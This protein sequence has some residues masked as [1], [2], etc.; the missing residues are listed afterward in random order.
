MADEKVRKGHYETS[1]RELD[2]T[3]DPITFKN[4]LEI[5]NPVQIP[6]GVHIYEERDLREWI[7]KNG[8]DPISR[9]PLSQNDVKEVNPTT[10]V[11]MN[12]VKEL[13]QENSDLKN[14]FQEIQKM[15]SA[16]GLTVKQQGNQISQQQTEL[17][18]LKTENQNL[19]TQIVQLKNEKNAL[20]N[21]LKEKIASTEE[22]Y[23]YGRN[24]TLDRKEELKLAV[25]L[26]DLKKTKF[27]IEKLN[28]DINT[29]GEH[30]FFNKNDVN[31]ETPLMVA[32]K[33]NQISVAQY[34]ISKNASFASCNEESIKNVR[35]YAILHLKI[36]AKLG[37]LEK[38]KFYATCEPLKNI[39][40]IDDFGEDS[41]FNGNGING[42][43]P[44]MVA[45]QF[46]QEEIVKYLINNK[47]DVNMI[48]KSGKEVFD[49]AVEYNSSENIKS[50][51]T[52][53]GATPTPPQ[54][55]EYRVCSC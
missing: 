23:E 45:V 16:I 11:L 34:L 43:S 32:I 31:G 9:A 19:T 52:Q 14:Q 40:C 48:S 12:S 24:A 54:Y 15:V 53:A 36:A 21:E 33:Y 22:T 46:N 44:L 6:S 18:S 10:K 49:Y 5:E 26:G 13:K 4:I 25:K 27:Y 30:L 42:K 1:I 17:N 55:K 41:A 47:S 35:K 28:V 38:V 2:D 37:D 7:E 39:I 8:S 50:M 3:T 29:V 51:L 20:A